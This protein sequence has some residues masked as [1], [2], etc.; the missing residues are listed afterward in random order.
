M[1]LQVLLRTKVCVISDILTQLLNLSVIP[2]VNVFLQC[3]NVSLYHL[4]FLFK[5]LVIK[6]E[7]L[8]NFVFYRA[9]SLCVHLFSRSVVLY[10]LVFGAY[11]S[12]S[13]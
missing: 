6:L 8:W 13:L 5:I 11:G 1:S 9:V 2:F 4:F 3:L 7:E 12:F 10:M